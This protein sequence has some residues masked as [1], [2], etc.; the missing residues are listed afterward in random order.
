MYKT[1]LMPVDVYEMELTDKAIRHAEYLVKESEGTIHL[2]YVLPKSPLFNTHGFSSDIRKF[3]EYLKKNAEE[4]MEELRGHFSLPKERVIL[5]IRY[6]SV[7]DEVNEVAQ[8]IHADVIIVGSKN[9]SIS[10]HLLGSNASSIIRHARFPVF[11]V[12]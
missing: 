7:R 3:D 10:T 6:G 2:L 1:I 11:V 12:R 9:P 4:K 5:E 8:E